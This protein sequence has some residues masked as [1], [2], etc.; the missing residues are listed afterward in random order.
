MLTR[1][2]NTVPLRSTGHILSSIFVVLLRKR[3][4]Q[5]SHLKYAVYLS[6][7][8]SH[9]NA[10]QRI[11]H[12]VLE[13]TKTID[14]DIKELESFQTIIGSVET[15]DELGSVLRLHLAVEQLLVFYI[16]EKS[17]GEVSK[18]AKAPRDFGGKLSLAT[19]FGLPISIARSIYQ[20]NVMR[21]K[22][23]HHHDNLINAGDLKELSRAVNSL[24]EIDRSFTPIEKRYIELPAKRPGERLAFG[25]EGNR[26]DFV[27]AGLSFY[28]TA[29]RWLIKDAASRRQ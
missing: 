24:S 21:N 25:A 14:L 17:Q 2:S 22:L 28:A 1:R 6:V 10:R 11:M 4:P 12:E 5:K 13:N 16:K 3:L 19:A 23:A 7:R 15:D 8:P 26:I 27:I 29:T 9:K 18:Y 20:I